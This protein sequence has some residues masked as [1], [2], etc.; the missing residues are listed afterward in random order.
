MAFNGGSARSLQQS[1][2]RENPTNFLTFVARW[3]RDSIFRT[4][5]RSRGEMWLNRHT[6]R[7]TDY[8][9]PPAYARRGLTRQITWVV[10]NEELIMKW[11]YTTYVYTCSSITTCV[12]LPTFYFVGL[13]MLLLLHAIIPCL[14]TW[15]V[16]GSLNSELLVGTKPLIEYMYVSKMTCTCNCRFWEFWA[17]LFG[18]VGVRMSARSLHRVY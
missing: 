8:S 7:Q 3:V 10:H 18:K 12:T 6:H 16:C 17:I 15:I 9:N 14:Y 13:C 11:L 4:N 1:S 5:R 2:F